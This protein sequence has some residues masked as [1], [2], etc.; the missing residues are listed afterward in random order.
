MNCQKYIE[1]I[2]DQL[3]KH[4]A[5][6]TWKDRIFQQDNALIHTDKAVQNYFSFKKIEVLIWFICSPDLNIIEN[7]WSELV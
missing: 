2:N 1:L 4:V 6:I 3:E 7:I 5:C